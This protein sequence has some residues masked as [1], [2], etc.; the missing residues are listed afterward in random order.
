M[1]KHEPATM[2]DK[3]TT[4]ERKSAAVTGAMLSSSIMGAFTPGVTG[5]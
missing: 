3:L 1:T 2:D 5:A 4:G